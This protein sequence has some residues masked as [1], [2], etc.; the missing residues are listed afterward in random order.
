MINQCFI[1]GM[2]RKEKG[3]RKRRRRIKNLIKG[4]KSEN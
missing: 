3:T 4:I 1:K 2:K